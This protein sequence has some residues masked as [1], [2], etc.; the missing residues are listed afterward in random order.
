MVA[1]LQRAA[2]GGARPQGPR[3][4]R[5]VA[6]PRA[7]SRRSTTAVVKPAKENAADRAPRP[8]SGRS[9]AWCAPG[10]SEEKRLLDDPEAVQ[11]SLAEL[12]K[13]KET[14]R[15][16]HG[17][18]GPLERARRRPGQR[19][20]PSRVIHR[21]RGGMR[22][23]YRGMDEQIE[24]LTKGDDWDEMTRELQTV[25]AD[26]VTKAFVAIEEGRVATREAVVELLAG[27]RARL[28]T[29][30][31]SRGRGRRE[32]VLAGQ[33]HRARRAARPAEPSRP[34]SAG[35]AVR[36]AASTCSA[37]WATSCRRRPRCSWRPTR[38]CWAPAPCSAACNSWTTA[39]ARS[40]PRRQAART[41]VRQ[42]IDDV[43]FE[44]SN[45]MSGLV[46]E[47]QRSLRDEF[48]ERTR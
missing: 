4:Q 26:E 9:P 35:S 37:C 29:G 7:R 10:S 20:C 32:R 22:A 3:P 1:R 24:E 11:R 43:Q 12:E 13:A 17:S 27:G 16:P 28:A 48:T 33:A 44:V 2:D 23:I 41:Q 31:G 38:C 5:R 15:A 8:I 18:G 6:V 21:F 39:S 47:A 45:E 36:R 42:F 46:K 34:A 19:T 25:V 30:A 14:P 40:P